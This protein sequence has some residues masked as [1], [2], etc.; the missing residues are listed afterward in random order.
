MKNRAFTLI[1][2][3]VVISIIALLSSVVL[4]SLNSAR[5]KAK[6]AAGKQ[7]AGNVFRVAADQAI[8]IYELSECSGT[9]ANDRSGSNYNL[10]LISTPSWPTDTPSGTGCALSFNGS[11]QYGTVTTNAFDKVNGN[12]LTVS[13]WIKPSRLAGQYQGIV[14]A[15][16]GVALDWHL[17]QHTTDGSVQLHGASQNKSTYV[18]TLNTWTHIAA[19]V[20]A[21]GKYTL[22]ANGSA[23]QTVTGYT[24][25]GGFPG[26]FTIGSVYG[27]VEPFQ[28][29]IDDVEVF[30]KSLT[31]SEVRAIYAISAPK[32]KLAD[33][34]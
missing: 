20:D 4:A 14:S 6:I 31:A 11:T 27:T 19:V 9:T 18:P 10:S 5:D 26:Q 28:G 17:Y 33:L 29:S 13:V 30:S 25:G 15:R 1:E 32:H 16:S 3:L 22:Y 21:A 12:E 7:F 8:G 24:Y 23:I 34:K 2:L